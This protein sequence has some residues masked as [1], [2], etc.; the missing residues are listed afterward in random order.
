[1]GP[2]VYLDTIV[3]LNVHSN[4]TTKHSHS[5]VIIEISY[6]FEYST[7]VNKLIPNAFI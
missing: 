5:N 2:W 3:H 6:A 7:V 1:M 4:A